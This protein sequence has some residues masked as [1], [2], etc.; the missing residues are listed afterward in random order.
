MRSPI[1]PVALPVLVWAA[2]T[3]AHEPRAGEISALATAQ[4]LL[5]SAC[6]RALASLA[7]DAEA[8]PVA[9]VALPAEVGPALRALRATGMG[10][11]V[12]ALEAALE[13]ASRLALVGARPDLESAVQ[14]FAPEDPEGLISGESDALT[15]AFR[16][17]AE[18]GLREPVAAAA[19]QR[20][21]EAGVP[22]AL[23]GVRDGTA[24]L[25]LPRKVDLDL[26]SLVTDHALD[27]FFVALADAARQ[28]R[29]ERVA[30]HNE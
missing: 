17:A 8:A 30:L 23:D 16:A 26:V 10:A 22:A 11:R 3:C 25:P 27:S 15:G 5:A 7:P 19:E 14:G 13:R 18:A 2:L 4:E 6:Q 24:R 20:L 21:A 12:T 1:L 29:R 28:L 9:P